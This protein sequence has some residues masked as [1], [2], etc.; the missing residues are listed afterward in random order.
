MRS[1]NGPLYPNMPDSHRCIGNF[2]AWEAPIAIYETFCDSA[3][4]VAKQM[5][6]SWVPT[7]RVE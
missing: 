3:V 5:P 4:F 2:R 6:S 7:V 1:L